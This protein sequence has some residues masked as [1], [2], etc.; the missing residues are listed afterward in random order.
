MKIVIGTR[1]RTRD[2]HVVGEVH[3]VVVDLQDRAVT[4][5]VV[6]KGRVLTRDILVP[7]DFIDDADQHQVVLRV[8][9]DRLDE[10]PEF[11]FTEFLAPPPAWTLAGP[12]PDGTVYVPVRQRKRLGEH[13]IDLAPGTPVFASDGQVGHVDQ[14]ELEPDSGELDAFWVRAGHVFSYD[15]RIPTEWV[16]SIDEAGV[17]V[18]GSRID[19]ETGLG[20]LSQ[21]RRAQ[22]PA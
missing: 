15:I 9:R 19:I 10:L 17:H 1:V 5:I 6:L 16:E 13:H 18:A 21:G 12:Y 7:L 14:V 11:V 2:R 22:T 8:D 3:R 20:P 4:A